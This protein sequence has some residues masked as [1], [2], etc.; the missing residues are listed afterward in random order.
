MPPA[1]GTEQARSGQVRSGQLTVT[2]DDD[3]FDIRA[4][5]AVAHKLQDKLT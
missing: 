3:D 1:A 5:A 2:E 4:P